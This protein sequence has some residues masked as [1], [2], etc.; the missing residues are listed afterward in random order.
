MRGRFFRRNGLGYIFVRERFGKSIK[1]HWRRPP[2]F[3]PVPATTQPPPAYNE[4][5]FVYYDRCRHASGRW[6]AVA[7]IVACGK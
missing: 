4:F 7:A 2:W 1:R 5:V 3:R 6:E